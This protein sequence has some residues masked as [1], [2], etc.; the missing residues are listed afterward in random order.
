M[1][2]A[3]ALSYTLCVL[4]LAEAMPPKPKVPG[5]ISKVLGGARPPSGSI[6]QASAQQT[7]ISVATTATD[8]SSA[9]PSLNKA[10]TSGA[11][12]VPMSSGMIGKMPLATSQGGLPDDSSPAHVS[13]ILPELEK[14]SLDP[15]AQ[16]SDTQSPSSPE[17][18]LSKP[19]SHSKPS[20]LQSPSSQAGAVQGTGVPTTSSGKQPLGASKTTQYDPIASSGTIASV[21][22][23][24][25]PVSRDQAEA[26]AKQVYESA[27]AGS[28]GVI[29]VGF[30]NVPGIGNVRVS[31]PRAKGPKKEADLVA[32]I[33]NLADRYAK[34]WIPIFRDRQAVRDSLKVK[35]VQD[36]TIYARSD[37][38]LIHVEDFAYIKV[39]QL[40]S[41]AGAGPMQGI[42]GV[43]YGRPNQE[44]PVATI[45]SP[46]NKG[47][48]PQPKKGKIMEPGCWPSQEKLGLISWAIK[49]SKTTTESSM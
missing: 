33:V 25:A 40:L 21:E 8:Q 22:R 49:G 4:H 43:A 7:D 18:G 29:M 47:P 34:D 30:V 23:S 5:N 2:V 9:T 42:Y 26:F 24:T 19:D 15:K 31:K 28:N 1:K 20:N 3:L 17:A 39:K 48:D 16:S 46:C 35:Q 27:A 32:A 11:K 6:A 41:E 37:L 44:Y 45:L 12:P 14:P 10:P 36:N 38:A 13:K